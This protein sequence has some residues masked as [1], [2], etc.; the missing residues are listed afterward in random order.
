MQVDIVND[1]VRFLLESLL[2]YVS[3]ETPYKIELFSSSNLDQY[4]AAVKSLKQLV[5]K[6]S[7]SGHITSNEF[8]LELKNTPGIMGYHTMMIF[9]LKGR[10]NKEEIG[11]ICLILFEG[12]KK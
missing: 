2:V 6:T 3:D 7:K 4:F 1:G 11:M 9:D 10:N 8:V 5:A 12:E